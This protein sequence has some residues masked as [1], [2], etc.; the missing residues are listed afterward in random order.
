MG[1]RNK[2]G[3]KVD[4]WVNLDKPLGLTST[5]AVGKIRRIMNGQKV[6]HAGTLDPLATGV[7]P[8]ALGEATKTIPYMQDA[9][10]GYEFTVTWGQQRSTDDAEGEVLLESNNRPTR[11]AIEAVLPLFM[12]DITQVPPK[13]SAVKI[14]GQ[15]A[16]DLARKG[17]E[18][19]I[20]S[21]EV[22]IESLELLDSDSNTATFT[23]TCGKGTYVRSIARDMAL[24]MDTYGYVSALK[25][26][27]VGAFHIDDTISLEVLEKLEHIPAR[28][29]ALKPV[30]VVLDDIPAL[31]IQ[32][33]E[34]TVL[35]NG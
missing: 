30:Q 10:K 4:G 17:E 6:G 33:G 22:Y 7:L 2:K 14:D 23:V 11:E 31:E 12:G 1:R 35:R 25:R 19:A 18:V 27:A 3:D 34:I 28:E 15:R 13:F 8:I 21:R 5:Q 26:T 16:Y 24:Q 29:A 9:L 20:K 32:A